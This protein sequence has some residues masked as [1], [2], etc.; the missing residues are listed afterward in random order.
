M[1]PF[2][3]LLFLSLSTL[4]SAVSAQTVKQVW[5]FQHAETGKLRKF[6]QEQTILVKWQGISG[7]KSTVGKLVDITSD[8]V[9]L[10]IQDHKAS[11][12]KQEIVAI[13]V[14][15]RH[16]ID[17]LFSIT[18]FLGGFL[19]LCFGVLL[20]LSYNLTRT[21]YQLAH[22]EHK[23]YWPWGLPG[24]I[25]IAWGFSSLK[26]PTTMRIEKPFA[27]EWILQEESGD[28]YKMP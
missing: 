1:R 13:G 28:S 16:F 19:I 17:K 25:L 22:G 21:D 15:E 20:Q 4:P 10:S 12:A 7:I 23:T 3:F 8:S 18:L 26:T 2:I 14:K 9:Q 24:L 27:Q 6:K 11:I 5:T